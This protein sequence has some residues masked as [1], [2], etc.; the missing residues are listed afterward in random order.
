MSKEQFNKN[1]LSDAELLAGCQ[2]GKVAYQELLYKQFFSFAMSICIRYAP[3]QGEAMEIVNDS[4]L[5]LFE[6][7]KDYNSAQP[8]KPWF[9]KILVNT[10]VD[11]YRKNQRHSSTLSIY[12]AKEIEE[13]DPEIDGNLVAEDIL[14]LFAHLPETYRVTFNLHE[15]E[16]Y[17]H[18]EIGEMLGIAP[19]TSRANLTRAKQMLRN[20]YYQHYNIVKDSHGTV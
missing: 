7:I 3:N 15:I 8:F 6:R 16:G 2:Q 12:C 19:S 9:A 1:Y 18:E 14:K 20:L 11:S 13:V 10:A 4:F 5:K 17:S